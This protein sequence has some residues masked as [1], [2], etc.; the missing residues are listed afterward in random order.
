MTRILPPTGHLWRPLPLCCVLARGF[1]RIGT[2]MT[3]AGT[4]SCV[5]P[6]RLRLGCFS[7]R[8][9]PRSVPLAPRQ[10]DLR[11]VDIATVEDTLGSVHW[12]VDNCPVAMELNEPAAVES[13]QM[14]GRRLNAN[15]GSARVICGWPQSCIEPLIALF[16]LDSLWL[17]SQS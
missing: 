12:D 10:G 17:K 5:P 7:P 9:R 3:V 11:H 14:R 15:G 16:L 6:R 4:S 13:R 2:P 8:N 1:P